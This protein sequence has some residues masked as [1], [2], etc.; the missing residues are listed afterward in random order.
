MRPREHTSMEARFVASEGQIVEAAGR[1]YE[2]S[3]K[4]HRKDNSR[5]VRLGPISIGPPQRGQF[6]TAT[7]IDVAP[8]SGDGMKSKSLRA[9]ASRAVRQG[10]ARYPNCRT[11]TN[12]R[13]STC[14]RNRRRNS[15][16]ARV[17]VRSWLLWA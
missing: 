6:Q 3:K 11:R 1:N 13:G 8:L 17:M 4:P 7:R 12:P 16:A 2:V 5:A 15:A 14:C 10:L 9:K